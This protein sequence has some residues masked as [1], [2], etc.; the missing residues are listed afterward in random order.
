MVIDFIAI[1]IKDK[2][3]IDHGFDGKN[4]TA[5]SGSRSSVG[6]MHIGYFKDNDAGQGIFTLVTLVNN[7]PYPRAGLTPFPIIAQW[8][9]VVEQVLK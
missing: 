6:S 9:G 8:D 7:V 1:A 5:F 2:E 3:P 4:G